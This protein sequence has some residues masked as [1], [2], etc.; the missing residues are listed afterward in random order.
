LKGFR[1]QSSKL[2]LSHSSDI[3]TAMMSTI[4]SLSLIQ[5]AVSSLAV[6]GCH[7]QEFYSPFTHQSFSK[8]EHVPCVSLFTRNGRMGCG[9]ASLASLWSHR[10]QRYFHFCNRPFGSQQNLAQTF[11]HGIGQN[12]NTK[13]ALVVERINVMYPELSYRCNGSKF[14]FKHGQSL[15]RNQI[16]S[17]EIRQKLTRLNLLN[18]CNRLKSCVWSIQ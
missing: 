2:Y 12:N 5:V 16:T 9:T 11:R 18:D 7:G 4:W 1:C 10:V 13:A 6:T 3:L 17:I 15:R 14:C 8:L